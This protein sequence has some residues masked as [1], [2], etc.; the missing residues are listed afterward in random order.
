MRLPW[1]AWYALLALATLVVVVLDVPRWAF[2]TGAVLVAVTLACF[3]DH[4]VQPIAPSSRLGKALRFL[5]DKFDALA[6]TIGLGF[7]GL[8]CVAALFMARDHWRP[9][10]VTFA[11]FGGGALVYLHSLMR[12]RREAR[13]EAI[14]VQVAGGV[15]IPFARGRVIWMA[16][17]LF[18]LG[19]IIFGVGT[20]YPWIFR[21]LGLFVAACGI[22][23]LGGVLL[24]FIGKQFIR[25]EPHGIVLG[26]RTYRSCI[27]WELIQAVQAFEHHRNPLV[28][29]HLTDPLLV[30][31]TPASQQ[32]AFLKR[33]RRNRIWVGPEVVIAAHNFGLET[34]P[35]VAALR[36]Y[37][38]DPA[39]R[40]ELETPAPSL[41][42][43]LA[44]R[45]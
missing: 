10:L 12:K 2:Y 14:Q 44:R 31:I 38:N 9:A 40:A 42:P 33:I 27:P 26:Q 16:L 3:Q 43:C 24:G 1:I 18:T 17:A 45:A 15:D 11:F 13:F 35:L 37:A 30:E 25:F 19:A 41:Q 21:V 28:G 4:L 22:A 5:G 32:G 34:P 36:R 23:M 20:D 29:V 7:C 8:M 39:A 6:E